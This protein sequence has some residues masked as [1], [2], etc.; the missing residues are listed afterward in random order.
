MHE[1]TAAVA[2][3]GDRGA[4]RSR[5]AEWV[6]EV[7]G[8]GG[9]AGG[10]G[11]RPPPEAR[12]LIVNKNAGETLLQRAARLGY[13]DVVLYCVDAG[14]CDVNHRD[15]A[16][17]CA[18][19]EACARGHMA[20]AR[21]LLA[22]GADVNCS[23]QDGT[24][25][26]HDAVESD[27][28]ELL[29]LLLAC[30]ADPALQPYSGRALSTMVHSVSMGA[31][32]REYLLDLRGRSPDDPG[33]CW[34]FHGSEIFEEGEE[35]CGYAVLAAPPGPGAGGGGAPVG[36]GDG[37]GDEGGVLFEFSSE[38]QLPAH[39]VQISLSQ[40]PRN[41]L[42]LSEVLSRV[43][44]SLAAF[45]AAL[46]GALLA[47]A[48]RRLLRAQAA[49]SQLGPAPAGD[50]GGGA[51]EEDGRGGAVGGDEA[52]GDGAAVRLVQLTPDL[53]ELLGSSVETL[54]SGC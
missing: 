46:P 1:N 36:P 4:L 49:A 51:A 15:N 21:A 52:G 45:R 10:A 29:R 48:P 16:G 24:R 13:R 35:Q 53:M 19:H 20:I 3:A 12:R 6:P 39:H 9:G 43:R 18:L 25:P 40:G 44:L 23:A 31:F 28:L 32:L 41:W 11:A 38:P 27:R 47:S 5:L 33:I 22:H 50:G 14:V 26:I 17:Y 2:A 8:G 42:L 37:G 54:P 30:G 7:A 34:D